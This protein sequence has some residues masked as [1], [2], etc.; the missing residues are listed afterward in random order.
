MSNTSGHTNKDH[1][2]YAAQQLKANGYYDHE[3]VVAD[4]RTLQLDYDDVP[5][6]QPMPERFAKVMDILRQALN[7]ES[8]PVYNV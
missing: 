2:V 4:D 8:P 7:K 1:A 5:F 6:G 3:V